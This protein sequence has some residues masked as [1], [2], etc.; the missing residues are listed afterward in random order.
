M[1]SAFE[2]APA[3]ESRSV[4][5]IAPSYGLFIDGEFTEAAGGKV[6]KTVSPSTEEVLSEV[7]QAGAEDVD[8]AVAAA[9]RAFEK[10]SALPGAERAKYL[11]RIARIVQERSR[12]LAVLETLDN[13]K[14]IRETRDADLPLV[15]AH[16]FYYAGWADKLDHAGY[17]RDPRPLGVAGQV[18]PWN[19]PLLMLAWKIAPALAA[20]NTVVLKPAE[21][22]PLSAL[23]FAD[24]CRQAGLPRGVVNILPG[25]GDAGAA[26]VAHEGVDKVAFTGSTAVGKAIARQVAGTRKKV[27]LELGGKGANIVFDDAPLDQAVEG[28]VTGIFFNQG[29]VCC[30]GS[31]LLVQESVQDE[32]LDALKRRLSTLRLGDPLDKNTDIGAINSAEQLARISALAD[33]GE[34]EG[35]ERWSPA[36][37]LP[38]AGYWFAPTLFTGVTQ[39]HTI[40]RDE[41]FGPVLS[42][43]TFRTPDEAVAKANNS[44]Y[45]LSAGIWTEKGSRILAVASKLRAGVVWANTFNKFDPT[46]P[47]G[48]YKESGFGREGGRHGLEAYLDV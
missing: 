18:I 35:A 7:A 1:A 14:P 19:F 43:L 17:G 46:S 34:A 32:L 6:F 44:Q 9:R 12:E 23:F 11:F 39:A 28:I 40:A 42:V 45:G 37:E 4:V 5:D 21:T 26:L 48:G 8:R 3:P 47:F 29:Q 22:T 33:T 16:F 15:A 25:Y 13:G 2:Y 36:C 41:I 10:W 27:T 24:V 31:R 38:S 30:A 20:G